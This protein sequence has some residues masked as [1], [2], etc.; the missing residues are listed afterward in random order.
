MPTN[1]RKTIT[2]EDLSKAAAAAKE[3]AEAAATTS[4][5]LLA[6]L[7][8]EGEEIPDNPRPA[9]RVKGLENGGSRQEGRGVKNG[10]G[11]E[12]RGENGNGNGGGGGR[13][14][15]GPPAFEEFMA[16]LQDA[17]QSAGN[18]IR[19]TDNRGWVK[20][21]S[22][23]NGHKVYV[24]KGKTAVNRIE[25][26]LDPNQLSGATEPDRD[27]G[28]IRSHLRAEIEVVS[29]AISL[30]V[31]EDIPPPQS[32]RGRRPTGQQER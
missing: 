24:A 21:E 13:R 31:D 29:Q 17:I 22:T 14:Q 32:R 27:N 18:G 30:L 26:T 12:A 9:Y 1:G 20:I 10:N 15:E 11:N 7:E 6:V 8:Q 25:S 23:V 16:A 5:A 4:E 19:V 2:R 3:A 28:L